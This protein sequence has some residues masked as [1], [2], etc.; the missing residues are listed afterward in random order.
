MKEKFSM[1]ERWIITLKEKM[2]KYFSANFTNVYIDMLSDLVK[3][4][5]NTTHSSIKMTLANASKQ[6]NEITIWRNLYTGL[7]FLLEMR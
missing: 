1:V 5:N 4:Y 3:E 7:S 2:W 6:E